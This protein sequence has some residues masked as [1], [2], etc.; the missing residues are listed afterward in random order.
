MYV[1]SDVKPENVLMATNGYLKL[2]D[3]GVAKV[4]QK[5]SSSDS[6]VATVYEYISFVVVDHGYLERRKFFNKRDARLHG[7]QRI[8]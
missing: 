2:S 1:S 4:F 7:L 5:S 8:E 3:F 6:L